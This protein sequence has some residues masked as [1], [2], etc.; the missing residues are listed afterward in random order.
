MSLAVESCVTLV[1][2]HGGCVSALL[3][4]C[5]DAAAVLR[6]GGLLMLLGP[7]AQVRLCDG[8]P[9]SLSLL[10]A[11]SALPIYF[12]FACQRDK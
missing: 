1:I 11:S 7:A 10:A 6:V 5:P 9:N 3:H 4:L 8:R 12:F 2:D